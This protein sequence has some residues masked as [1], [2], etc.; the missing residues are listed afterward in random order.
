MLILMSSAGT[1]KT[2][3]FHCE[4]D[5]SA[6][7]MRIFSRVFNEKVTGHSVSEITPAFVQSL[8]ISFGDMTMIMSSALM[9]LLGK[10]RQIL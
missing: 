9:A 4:F 6:D 8:G 1:M 10:P 3:V 5:L 7:I 2:R